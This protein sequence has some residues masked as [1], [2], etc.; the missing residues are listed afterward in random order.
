M[1]S[2][3]LFRHINLTTLQLLVAVSEEGTLTRAAAREAIAPSAVSKRLVELEQTLGVTLFE[4]QSKGMALTAAGETMLHHARQM[5]LNAEHIATELAEHAA[6]A[7]GFVRMLANL[8]AI[9]QFLPEDLQSFLAR[10]GDIK[11][12]L[13]ERPSS[14]VVS[15]VETAMAEIGICSSDVETKDLRRLAYRSDRLII[16]MRADNP[17]ARGETVAFRDT[18][19]ENYVGLHAASSIY[20]R[21]LIEARLAGKPL[22]LRIRVP[23]FDAVC[24]MVQAGM[25]IGILPERAYE[26]LGRPMGLRAMRLSDSW[27]KRELLVVTRKLPLSPVGALLVDHLQKVAS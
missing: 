21:S 6:G 4:R 12:D 2:T 5:L 19:D 27:A 22:K 13:E 3:N 18:L 10:H 17:L 24:R 11:I 25:G 15:G 14:G 20:T 26:L 1:T 9:V 8:S 23:S 16:V 7:R